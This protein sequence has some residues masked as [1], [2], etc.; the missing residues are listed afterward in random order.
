MT[1]CTMLSLLL[2]PRGEKMQ[3]CLFLSLEVVAREYQKDNVEFLT[4]RTLWCFLQDYKT[5]NPAVSN[6]LVFWLA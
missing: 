4:A 6:S 1:T 5:Q 2:L 3:F